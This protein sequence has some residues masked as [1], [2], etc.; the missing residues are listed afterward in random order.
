MF[1]HGQIMT[2]AGFTAWIQQQQ[3]TF[4]PVLK[5]LVPYSNTYLPDPAR[6]AG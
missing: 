2:T 5:S 6:R 3:A 1:D 4:A